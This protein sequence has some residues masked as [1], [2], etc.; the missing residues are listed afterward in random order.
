[1]DHINA[2]VRAMRARLITTEQYRVLCQ[3]QSIEHFRAQIRAYPAYAHGSVSAALT[4]ELDRMRLFLGAR[5]QPFLF[6]ESQ[7]QKDYIQD[8]LH[9]KTLPD[10][11]NR[12][13]LIYIKGAEIDLNNILWMYRLKKYYPEETAYP[14]LV[15]ICHR[16]NKETVKQMAESPGIAEF[17][18]TVLHTRYGHVF[19]S[20]DDPER[21]ISQAMKQIFIRMT[22]R[23]PRSI[24]GVMGYFFDKKTEIRNLTAVMEGI[25]YQLSPDEVFERL[26]I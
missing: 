22:K 7:H 21:A 26:I 9:I 25:R 24:A 2:K 14:H 20:F 5:W 15:P 18:V 23:Y 16:L 11:Q 19:G 1:M 8:W 13:A 12:Q 10:G 6:F 4:E 3:S 17:I